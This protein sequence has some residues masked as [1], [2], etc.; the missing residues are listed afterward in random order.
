VLLDGPQRGLQRHDRAGPFGGQDLGGLPA[1]ALQFQG[2]LE[3]VDAVAVG[4]ARGRVCR[5]VL[6]GRM[7]GGCRLLPGQAGLIPGFG[8]VSGWQPSS[9]R[10][11]AW[12]AALV[13]AGIAGVGG[14]A[15]NFL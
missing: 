10:G 14:G 9:W 13:L 8:Q 11:V 6:R 1:G 5:W 12:H 7:P 2:V 15:T 3:G 4:P